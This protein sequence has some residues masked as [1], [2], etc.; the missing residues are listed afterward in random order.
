LPGKRGVNTLT[1][2]LGKKGT[3][4]NE[5]I[6]HEN[7]AR[8]DSHQD[9]VVRQ[10]T[11]LI[12]WGGTAGAKGSKGKPSWNLWRELIHPSK[13]SSE[14]RGDRKLEISG[15]KK[16]VLLPRGGRKGFG[17]RFETKYP[18]KR[19]RKSSAKEKPIME[20]KFRRETKKKMNSGGRRISFTQ[21][22]VSPWE[23]NR[24]SSDS[25]GPEGTRQKQNRS[26]NVKGKFRASKGD[27]REKVS[28]R[29]NVGHQAGSRN[30]VRKGEEECR[31]ENSRGICRNLR[32]QQPK[33]GEGR[34][35]R[36][37]GGKKS[38]RE[39][40]PSVKG[41]KEGLFR[42]MLGGEKVELYEKRGSPRRSGG[43]KSEVSSTGKLPGG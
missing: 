14:V 13:N 40:R 19:T 3:A 23:K 15:D 42:R 18:R 16:K 1:G 34:G 39:G 38:A 8:G 11:L 5:F 10:R 6:H 25:S 37:T 33:R 2:D 21:I 35:Q 9:P 20:E 31:K 27:R 30:N 36:K 22:N 7:S 41:K 29:K 4:L 17:K 43:K 24:N 26:S 12:F 28:K 32:S